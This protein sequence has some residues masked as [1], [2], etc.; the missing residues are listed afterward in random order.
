VN[1][2]GLLPQAQ[3]AGL[4]AQRSKVVGTGAAERL[5]QQGRLGKAGAKSLPTMMRRDWP[6]AF[7]SAALT[8]RTMPYSS[9][10]AIK[11]QSQ[12]SDW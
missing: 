2:Q 4:E 3:Q 6:R 7:S 5:V 12:S 9:S 8:K 11:V 1:R 10:T